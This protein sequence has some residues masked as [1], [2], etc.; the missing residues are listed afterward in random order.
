[1]HSDVLL[2]F[3]MLTLLRGFYVYCIVITV[4]FFYNPIKRLRI[5]LSL[6]IALVHF[7]SLV[8]VGAA[9]RKTVQQYG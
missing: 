9:S 5:Q 3:K 6:Y 1:M 4:Y 2:Q 7:T 8:E